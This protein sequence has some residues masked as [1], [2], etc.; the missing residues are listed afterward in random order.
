MATEQ[1]AQKGQA[2]QVLPQRVVQILSQTLALA[3]TNLE[4]LLFQMAVFA[5]IAGLEHQ[6]VYD[7]ARI[8]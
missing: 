6:E 1:L 4:H 3:L 5:D 2:D 8:Q 7:A